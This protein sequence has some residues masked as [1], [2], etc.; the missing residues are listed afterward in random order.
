MEVL[1]CLFHYTVH[2]FGV[3]EGGLDTLEA[4]GIQKMQ[5]LGN[6]DL[7]IM[8]DTIAEGGD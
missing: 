8:E 4:M 6:T 1:S 5:S 7:K 2:L 3:S